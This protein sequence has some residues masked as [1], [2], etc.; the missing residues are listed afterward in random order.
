MQ[1]QPDR[2]AVRDGEAVVNFAQLGRWSDAVAGYIQALNLDPLRPIAYFGSQ[3]LHLIIT[4][5]ACLK[6]GVPFLPIN[7]QFPEPVIKE[8][9]RRSNSI[10]CFTD[11]ELF[12]KA[13]FLPFHRMPLQPGD[14]AEVPAF[15]RPEVDDQL[16]ALIQCSSGPTG[17]PKLIP[18]SRLAEREY[19]RIHFEVMSI[20]SED[21]VAHMDLLWLES[22][23]SALVMGAQVRCLHPKDEGVL[24]V[25]EQMIEQRVSVLPVYPSLFRMFLFKHLTIPELRIVMTSGEALNPSDLRGFDAL[26]SPG[27]EIQNWYASMEMTFG[28]VNSHY[29]GDAISNQPMPAGKPVDPIKLHIE[30]ED[31]DLLGNGEI[32]EIV[33]T[34]HILLTAY[35]GDP[36]RSGHVFGINGEGERTY[37]T[38]DY[39]FFDGQENL[40]YVARRDDQLKISGFN[41]RISV[42]ENELLSH[43]DVEDCGV[44]SISGKRQ[45]SRLHGFYVGN[46]VP[47]IL[48][49]YLHDAL[50][51]YMVPSSLV[52]V[53]AIPKTVTGKT[54]RSV[55]RTMAPVARQDTPATMTGQ[56][57]QIAKVWAQVLEHSDFTEADNFA[58]VGGDSLG[59]MEMLIAVEVSFNI[60]ISLDQF[61]LMGGTI[62]ALSDALDTKDDKRLRVM[63]PGRGKRT[64][65]VTH[66]WTGDV[67]SY[68]DL[69]FTLDRDTK[70]VGITADYSGRSRA[71]SITQ[72]AIEA[73]KHLPNEP[74]RTLVGYSFG[75]PLAMEIAR[76]TPQTET[77]LILID[78]FSKQFRGLKTLRFW[79]AKLEERLARKRPLGYERSAPQDYLYSPAPIN[80]HRACLFQGA[81]FPA[82]ALPHWRAL[83]GGGLDVFEHHGDHVGMMRGGRVMQ[84]AAQMADWLDQDPA[85]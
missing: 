43:P 70:V 12:K 27:A 29:N 32:G 72:K 66:T 58:D 74:T 20:T 42:V 76:L 38:G 85:S 75:A 22:P 13:A 69:A 54:Q 8:V 67:S 31:G 39:G 83:F 4:Y 59:A 68:L 11:H 25:A 7:N 80:V 60:R 6:V 51:S 53:K 49:A 50:P 14:S 62:R 63:K 57:A 16:V 9:F 44:I 56:K 34:S 79:G 77:Q 71:I 2:I 17:L 28:A 65:Y 73:V 5:I 15:V 47:Q 24:R 45:A 30:G 41:V 78:P 21:V 61:I 37:R 18:Y 19:I 1:G 55:L 81:D 33:A 10:I 23:L 52:Q 26:T 35:L 48:T 36:E 82:Y 64:L 46:V 40:R 84:I 3:G